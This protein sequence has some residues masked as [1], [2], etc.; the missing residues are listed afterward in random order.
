MQDG[1]E[2][3][4]AKDAENRRKHGITFA[5]AVMIFEGPVL[6][7]HDDRFEYGEVREVSVGL[8]GAAVVLTVAHTERSG[9]R[10]LISARK[11][12][13]N[14]RRLFHAHLQRALG[15]A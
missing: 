14:E 1:F 2:W 8:L 11:A 7:R 9:V 15:R 6:T 3:D 10:R 5:E 13:P 12:T 4:P